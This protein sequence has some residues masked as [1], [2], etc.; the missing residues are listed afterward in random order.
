MHQ[1]FPNRPIGQAHSFHSGIRIA[2]VSESMSFISFPIPSYCLEPRHNLNVPSSY[3]SSIVM[4]ILPS[5]QYYK[6]LMPFESRWS[7]P[8]RYWR[9]SILYSWLCKFM[10]SDKIYQSMI[11]GDYSVES[12]SDYKL[13]PDLSHR[14]LRTLRQSDARLSK[15][16]VAQM[17]RPRR[18]KDTYIGIGLR[19]RYLADRY[20]IADA[21]EG[22]LK[23]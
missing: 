19:C 10:V 8:C 21:N 20:K 4:S 15:S 12:G 3:P 1:P 23:N 22:R 18:W 13:I 14:N 17:A 9:C 2:R 6:S 11:D 16:Y 5:A 7:C